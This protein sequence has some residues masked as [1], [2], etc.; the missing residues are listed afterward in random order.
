LRT[1]RMVV[2]CHWI[3]SLELIGVWAFG[4]KS[5]GKTVSRP[6]A[7]LGGPITASRLV[8]QDEVFR[9]ALT[10]TDL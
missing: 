6:C 4:R 2:P 1:H 10:L 9:C 5:I 3:G 7:M 8:L